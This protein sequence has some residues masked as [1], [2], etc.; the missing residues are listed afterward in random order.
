MKFNNKL[1][2]I[3]FVFMFLISFASAQSFSQIIN[4]SQNF[5]SPSADSVSIAEGFE[6]TMGGQAA[7]LTEIGLHPSVTATKI[8]ILHTDGTDLGNFT[9]TGNIATPNVTLLADQIYHIEAHNDQSAYDRVTFAIGAYPH[10]GNLINWTAG[11]RQGASQAGIAVSIINLTFGV[12]PVN[13]IETTTLSPDNNTFFSG[14]NLTLTANS[15]SNIRINITNTS[16]TLWY[17]NTTFA[18]ATVNSSISGFIND[19]SIMFSDLSSDKY[20][21]NVE[22]C[23]TNGTDTFCAFDP[24]NKTMTVGL[25]DISFNFTDPISETADAA[26]NITFNVSSGTPTAILYVN[27]TSHAATGI[28]LQE[29]KWR[30]DSSFAIP[31]GVGIKNIIWEI[32]QDGFTHNVSSVQTVALTN[33]SIC[34]TAPQIVSYINF[35]F[36][37]ETTAEEEITSTFVSTWTYR[38]GS[39]ATVNKTLT[40]T[41]STERLSFAFCGTPAEQNFKGSLSL[42][43]DNSESEQ[44]SFTF[45]NSVLSNVTTNTVLYLLPTILG[46]FTTYQ[47]VDI[48]GRTIS[49]V[50]ATV[51]RTLGGNSIEVLTERTDG[52]G[53]MTLFLNPDISYTYVFTKLG[54]KENSFSLK[55]SSPDPYTITMEST[56]VSNVTGPTIVKNLTVVIFPLNSTL[57][58]N[59]DYTFAINITSDQAISSVLLNITFANGTQAFPEITGSTTGFF[60]A[61][62]N[63]GNAT[64]LIGTYTIQTLNDTITGS[65]TWLIADD[66]IGDYSL[67]KQFKLYNDF[68]F[69]EIWKIFFVI[70][71]IFGVVMLLSAQEVTDT[72]ESK[73]IAVTLMVWIF[74]VVGWLDIAPAVSPG[75]AGGTVLATFAK[76]YGIAIVTSF[77]AFF[78]VFRRL[79]K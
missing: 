66:F 33:F 34:G 55:P 18:S 3:S 24:S 62:L 74:S 44:R 72:S 52:S 32:S 26:Y 54:F 5:T 2:L 28:N 23:G 50:L 79:I 71:S 14:R 48:L 9:I 59:T 51:T 1:V 27:G 11:S 4:E 7:N 19:T 57:S 47:T 46:Q 60:S 49:N 76:Q 69:R 37:N 21:W 17:I 20:I 64:T 35:T 12:D 6:I 56:A 25:G 15:F 22:S 45:T 8:Q 39:D 77:V 13:D 41:D 58:N 61:V 65:K 36:K 78:L 16:F 68:G 75:S 10:A 67:F 31:V 70:F 63:T 38:L 43:Y 29:D 30:F 73:V 42:D 40:F 53:T